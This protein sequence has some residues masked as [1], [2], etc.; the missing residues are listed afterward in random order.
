MFAMKPRYIMKKSQY[1]VNPLVVLPP[2]RDDDPLDDPLVVLPPLRDDDPLVVLPP[3]RDDDPLV[4]LPMDDQVLLPVVTPHEIL[5]PNFHQI[6]NY[7]L[8]IF[9]LRLEI[10]IVPIFYHLGLY[11]HRN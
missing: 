10:E 1:H 5:H 8:N 6:P 3:L 7:E 11:Y 4:V 9:D 2:L